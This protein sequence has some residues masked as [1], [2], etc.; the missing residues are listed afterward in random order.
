M[1]FACL[2]SV[3]D[4]NKARAF[5]EEIFDLKVDA[6][7]G[8][9]VGFDCGL[10]LQQDFSWLTGIPSEEIKDRE[11]SFEVYFEMQD[12][13]EFVEKLKKRNDIRLL[14][15]VKEHGWGQ[16]VIRFYDLDNHLIEVGES[17]KSV[18]EKFMDQGMTLEEVAKRIDGTVTDVEKMLR[19]AE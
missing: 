14:H 1:I 2:L 11:N 13:D 9:N 17:M 12:F 18:I 8:I 4:I 16:R 5:Y 7:F 6:D 3:K 15:D 10:A 19:A